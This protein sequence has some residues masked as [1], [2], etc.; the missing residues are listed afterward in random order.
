MALTTDSQVGNHNIYFGL[1]NHIDI[2]NWQPVDCWHFV[3]DLLNR[4]WT[5]KQVKVG[6]FTT[7]YWGA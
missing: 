5:V 4:G 7:I 1:T 2:T 3:E 6:L